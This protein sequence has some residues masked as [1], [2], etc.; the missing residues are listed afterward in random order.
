MDVF[1]ARQPIFNRARELVAYELLFR[2][3]ELATEFDGTGDESATAQVIANSL[4][5][6]GLEKIIG[7]TKAFINFND[8]LLRA[9]LHSM[10][11]RD[12]IVLEL[13]EDVDP[14]EDVAA[15]CRALRDE[16]YTIA[17]DDFSGDPRFEALTRIAQLIKVDIQAVPQSEQERILRTYRPRGIAMLAERVETAEE[18]ERARRL[19]YDHFQ[20]FFFARPSLVRGRQIPAAKLNCL[21]LLREMQSPEL[22]FGKLQSIISQDLS[23][24]YKLLR[25]VNSALF[26]PRTEIESIGQSLMMLGEDGVRH[27]VA[28]AALPELAKD[29]PGELV[30]HS[31]VRAS[32]CERLAKLAGS[33]QPS[34]G[35]LMGMFSL[36]DALVDLPL[37]EALKQVGVGPVISAALLGT[38]SERNRLRDVY[39][40]ACSYET[41]DWK[42]VAAAVAKLGFDSSRLTRAYTDSTFWAQRAL[43]ATTRAG[44]SRRETRHDVKGSVRIRWED[45]E[46][47]E[48]IA[49]AQI[50]NI[51]KSGMHLEVMDKIPARTLVSLNDPQI[52]VSGTGSVRYCNSSRG[53][54]FIG[55]EFANGTGWPQPSSSD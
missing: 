40:L 42:A 38:A 30:T 53:R 6:I 49:N 8:Q 45:E 52:G 28:L 29:K 55:L 32:F 26:S 54:Y 36:L 46:G 14:N 50:R 31:L 34:Q 41:C 7:R 10:L 33:P 48:K 35:F 3:H 21:Q 18:F 13:L 11:P 12:Q 2:S 47:C 27:W 4:L 9:G 39:R 22:D 15:L 24:S 43:H 20:G 17:L 5:S 51:S 44:N 19:G 37:E 16:G 25:Y 1:V 23:F